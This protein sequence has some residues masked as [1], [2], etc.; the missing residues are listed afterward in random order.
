MIVRN[1]LKPDVFRLPIEKIRAGYKT[2]TYFNRTKHILLNDSYHPMVTMQVFQKVPNAVVCGVDQALAILS[3][4]TGYYRNPQKAQ[5][6][7][8]Q[9]LGLEKQLY[10]TWL[11]LREIDWDKYQ[12]VARPIFEVSQE[13]DRLWINCFQDLVV[14]ALYDGEEVGD[15]EPVMLIKGDLATFVHLETLYL[16]AL[17]DGTMVA[18]NTRNVVKAANGKP[19]LMFAARHQAHESQAGGGYAAYVA[20]VMGVSTDEQGEYWGSKGLGTIPHALIAA[21]N[22]NT[23]LATM[24]FAEFIDPEVKVISLVDFDNDS[25]NT[26]LEVANILGKRLW[27]VRLDTASNM[28]DRSIWENIMRGRQMA[29]GKITGVTPELVWNVR[30][31]LDQDGY[32]HVKIIASGGFNAEKIRV[33]ERNGVPVDVYGVGSAL[34]DRQYGKFEYTADVSEPYAKRGRAFSIN[35]RLP[36]VNLR[37]LSRF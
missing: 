27:G 30:K 14:R 23:V 31:A 33:F 7:F 19:I 11:H 15:R 29:A 35:K 12:Q 24:K 21:Y 3:V 8:A 1:R 28:V 16:G 20:G 22:G 37:E 36:F 5:K 25:V 4:G 2:D 26:S 13:L 32:H 34:Y 10:Q 17:T 18:T 9:Y 6:L